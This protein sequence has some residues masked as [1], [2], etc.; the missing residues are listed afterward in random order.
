M[1]NSGPLSSKSTCST[2]SCVQRVLDSMS[3][4]SLFAKNEMLVIAV[5][6]RTAKPRVEAAGVQDAFLSQDLMGITKPA[7]LRL[8]P[9]RLCSSFM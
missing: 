5:Y 8:T 4:S 9:A 2:C 3:C 6:N 7:R 1:A